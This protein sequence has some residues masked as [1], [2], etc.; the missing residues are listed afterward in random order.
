[1][2][3]RLLLFS[4]VASLNIPAAAQ[5]ARPVWSAPA[6]TQVLTEDKTF[7]RAGIKLAGKLYLPRASDKVPAVVVFHGA[8]SP[9]QSAALYEHLKRM[10]PPLGVAVFTYDRRGTGKSTGKASGNDYESL[11]DDEIAAAQMLAS[12]P[13]IEFSTHRI[14]GASAKVAG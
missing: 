2:L 6:T 8:S 5:P 1:M 3:R 14:L 12:D 4:L 9:L 10:L 11:A 7:D 13:R